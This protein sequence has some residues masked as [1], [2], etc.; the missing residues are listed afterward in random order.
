M[1]DTLC[2][3]RQD[4][5][6][7]CIN[8]TLDECVPSTA[9]AMYNVTCANGTYNRDTFEKVYSLEMEQTSSID[10][11][12]WWCYME[13]NGARSNIVSLKMLGKTLFFTPL[14]G[15]LSQC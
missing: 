12:K 10:A 14:K 15:I 7:W 8:Q 11:K 9:D 6:S 2:F 1:V 4:N 5:H 3:H 13:K